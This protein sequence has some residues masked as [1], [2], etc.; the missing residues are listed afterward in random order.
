MIPGVVRRTMM[1]PAVLI[2]AQALWVPVLATAQQSVPVIDSVTLREDD[3]ARYPVIYP[4]FH[5]HDA[6][7]SVR[8]IHREVVTTNS[9]KPLQPRTDAVIDIS[10]NQQMQGATYV[11]GWHCGPETYFVTLRAYVVNREGSKSN[12]VEYTIHCN[13]G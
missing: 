4:E 7:G 8:F 12:L 13:G 9:P 10:A 1:L 2:G 5:F 11:G 6:S 3:G